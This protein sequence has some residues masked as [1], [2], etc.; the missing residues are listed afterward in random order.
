[1]AN[2]LLI[3]MQRAPFWGI[4]R[5]TYLRKIEEVSGTEVSVLLLSSPPRSDRFV[6]TTVLYLPSHTSSYQNTN[7]AGSTAIWRILP[8]G[9]PYSPHTPSYRH[10][11]MPGGIDHP[12]TCTDGKWRDYCQQD[13]SQPDCLISME[14]YQIDWKAENL[15]Y[16]PNIRD[17]SHDTADWSGGVANEQHVL[18]ESTDIVWHQ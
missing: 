18:R 14:R 9:K 10:D 12:R 7:N 2:S 4:R 5:M 3:G 11:R 6:Y 16:C 13:G 1:M 17:W 8:A 15:V